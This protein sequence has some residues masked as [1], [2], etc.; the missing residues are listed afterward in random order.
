VELAMAARE[1][2]ER[3]LDLSERLR[4]RHDEAPW[5]L[6][7]AGRKAGGDML[8]AREAPSRSR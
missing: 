8:P 2:T 1:L 5:T 4:H 3:A 7:R 6:R